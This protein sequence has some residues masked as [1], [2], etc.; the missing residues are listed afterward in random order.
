M[1][2][3]SE[4]VDLALKFLHITMCNILVA[5][6]LLVALVELLLE[7]SLRVLDFLVN[8]LDDS[9]N[10]LSL[11]HLDEDASFESKHRFLNDSIV[12][13]DH[14]GR[15]LTLE[16]RVQVHDWLELVLSEAIGVN[17]MEGSVE[18]FG[19]VAKEV[20]ITSDD[21]LVTEFDMEVLLVGM[22]EPDA[23]LAILLFGFLEVFR[24]DIDLFVDFFIFFKYVLLHHVEAR[25][26]ILK[27]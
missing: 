21:G 17:V 2:R 19:L 13:V 16:V 12:E 18:E 5:R 24:D 14:V 20:L 1:Y 9:V 27:E 8:I 7:A 10:I 25:F 3:L 22:A 26:E 23:V 6:V 4:M 15:D 11:A